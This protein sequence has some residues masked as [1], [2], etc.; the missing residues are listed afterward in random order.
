MTID[1]PELL[2]Y[3]AYLKAM[4]IG[5]GIL[6]GIEWLFKYRRG[7]IPACHT[8]VLSKIKGWPWSEQMGVHPLHDGTL[9]LTPI[10]VDEAIQEND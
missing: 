9:K 7:D 3:L 8:R 5:A 6:K 2:G 10:R 1:D 4:G